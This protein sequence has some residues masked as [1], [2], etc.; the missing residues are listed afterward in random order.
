MC[1][2]CVFYSIYL[3][4]LKPNVFMVTCNNRGS[5]WDC[6][7][8]EPLEWPISTRSPNLYQLYKLTPIYRNMEPRTP[9]AIKALLCI[10]NELKAEKHSRL[11]LWS[12][13][14]TEP[15][16]KFHR[17]LMRPKIISRA[18]IW[19]KCQTANE[20][21]M[22]TLGWDIAVKKILSDTHLNGI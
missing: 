19:F 21:M 14:A 8:P 1:V 4:Q 22:N 17:L 7:Y 13:N 16:S 12:F 2:R 11:Y 6:Y 15:F 18:D 20:P 10:S 9:E 3:L 5:A